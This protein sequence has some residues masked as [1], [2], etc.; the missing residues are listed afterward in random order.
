MGGGRTPP[1]PSNE[2]D[3]YFPF[4]N[5]WGAGGQFITAR[6]NFATDSD[7]GCDGFFGTGHIW[8]AGGY[9]SNGTPLSS[10]EIYCFPYTYGDCNSNTYVYSDADRNCDT[11]CNR[12]ASYPTPTPTFTP[13]PPHARGDVLR[14]RDRA[15]LRHRARSL[16]GWFRQLSGNGSLF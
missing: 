15:L 9:D 7:S 2:I 3:I 16:C 1:N 10:T 12:N 11:Y 5:G 6:R 8:L 14:H 4:T 13:T